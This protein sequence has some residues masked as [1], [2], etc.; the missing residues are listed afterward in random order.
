M[1]ITFDRK[2]SYMVIYTLAWLAIG[3][4]VLLKGWPATWTA[5]HIPIL[6]PSLPFEDMRTV[7]GSL[8]SVDLGLNPQVQN[9]GDPW[10][11]V[12]NYPI[13]WYWIARLF[14]FDREINFILFVCVYILAYISAC[15]LLLWKSPSIYLLLAVFS[16]PSLLA[17]E[18]GNNDL[19]AFTLVFAGITLSQ[20]YWR[21]FAIFLA[22]TLKVYPVLLLVALLKKP[23]VLIA[24]ALIIAGLFAFNRGELNIIQAGNTASSDPASLF[25]SYGLDTTL[26]NIQSLIPDPLLAASAGFKVGAMIVSFL[27]IVLLSWTGYF[28]LEHASLYKTDLFI[29]GGIVFSGTFL[30]TSNWDYRLIF[31][32][33][34]IPHI[35]SIQNPLVKH[36]ILI[37]I[38]LSSNAGFFWENPP[39][40]SSLLGAVIKYFVFIM[41][42]VGLL[43]E[44]TNTIPAALSDRYRKI[45]IPVVTSFRSKLLSATTLELAPGEARP[46]YLKSDWWLRV[47]IGLAVLVY[48]NHVA[49]KYFLPR[50]ISHQGTLTL[51][52]TGLRPP[53]NMIIRLRSVGAANSSRS[54]YRRFDTP[55]MSYTVDGLYFGDYVIQVIHDENENEIADVD[56]QTGLF[57]EGFGM[58]NMDRLDLRNAAALKAGEPFDG[59]KYTFNQRGKT[60]EIQI[61]YPP[62]PWQAP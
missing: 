32:L 4:A 59:L 48:F 18:R 54:A 12:M 5:L 17:V 55:E 1:K 10:N 38:L 25:A 42:S 51:H 11:R 34:C 44:L 21:A 56:S 26:R 39:A 22:T 53:G 15:F 28:Q 13:V 19:L 52:I 43:K 36:S 61:V 33:F 37:G 40:W 9:P 30:I 27:L 16:W 23:K 41:V 35:L 2:M 60:V 49:Q 7:Q 31:L 8:Q 3:A 24:L 29:S 57:L 62:F 45:D 46:F 50:I 6:S 58:A 20:R 47:F 14:Q